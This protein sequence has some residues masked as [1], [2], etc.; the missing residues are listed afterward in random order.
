M[1]PD[2]PA[3]APVPADPIPVLRSLNEAA[4]CAPDAH[5]A[6]PGWLGERLDVGYAIDVLP[7]P[8]VGALMAKRSEALARPTLSI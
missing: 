5:T 1:I 2:V 8:R 4:G 3:V 7:P 6:T